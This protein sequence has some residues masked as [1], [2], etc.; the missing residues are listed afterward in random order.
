MSNLQ[1]RVLTASVSAPLAAMPPLP[2]IPPMGRRRPG[3]FRRRSYSPV[4][5]R[6]YWDNKENLDTGRGVF[7]VYSRGGGDTLVLLLHGGGYSALTWSLAA[8]QLYS[9]AECRIA[10]VDFRGHGG[11]RAAEGEMVREELTK[12][13]QAVADTLIAQGGQKSLVLVGHSMG[14]AIAVSAAAQGGV[15][16]LVVIDVVEGTAMESLAHMQGFLR[17]RPQQFRSVSHAIEWCVRSGQSR[18]LDSA[19]VSMPGQIVDGEGRLVSSLVSER[20]QEPTEPE[21]EAGKRMVP[22]P[23]PD[24]IKE[25]DEENDKKEESS[26]PKTV[27]GDGDGPYRWAVDLA[28]TEPHWTGW[29]EN[30]SANFLAAPAAKLLILAGVDRLDKDMTVGQMQGKFQMLVLPQVG[31]AIQEDSP[32]KVAEAIANFLVRNRLA[33]SKDSNIFAPKFPLKA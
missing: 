18:N 12:D 9:M 15:A 10:A 22:P 31:H 2:Q 17:S 14:G 20:I 3:S 23:P 28:G 5:W 30:L 26:K 4:S 25:E 8:E 7:T 33:E 11:T 1:R 16:G 32:E 19:K 27:E 29:F 13:I 6:K 24:T 21:V